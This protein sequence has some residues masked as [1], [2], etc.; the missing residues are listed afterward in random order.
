LKSGIVNNQDTEYLISCDPIFAHI[1]NTYGTPPDWNRP[2]GF[3]SLCR[4]ILE[5][6]VSLASA[7]A[8]YLKLNSYLSSFSPEEM[9]KLTDEE[10]RACQISRQKATYLRALSASILA[11]DLNLDELH[12]FAESE[13]REKLIKIKGIGNWTIDVYLMFCLRSKDVFP[14]GD[15]ALI[16]TVKQLTDAKTTDDILLLAEKWRPYRSLAAYFIW[17]YYLKK[18]KRM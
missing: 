5:Q 8:H 13:V 11:R 18:R 17:Y 7:N 6:Q 3:V 9:I 16:N 12:L 10:M 15:I 1:F 2:Q 4:I 14:I